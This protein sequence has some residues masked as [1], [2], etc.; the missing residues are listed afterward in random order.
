MSSE[1][2][3]L[4]SAAA[5]AANRHSDQRRKDKGKTPYINH[6][7]A[8]A[9]LL[10]VDGNVNDVELLM[11]ALL[12]DTV[13]DTATSLDELAESFGEDVRDLV[14]EVSDDKSLPKHRRKEL[15]VEN[16][17]RKSDSAKQL[18]IADKICNIRDID[19]DSPVGWDAERKSQYLDWASK[20]VDG[21]RGVNKKLDR[22][23]DATITEARQRLEKQRST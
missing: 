2:S 9:C 6:P 20:V 7:L 18:K 5:F 21:C 23:F 1:I 3:Q 22:L 8:V 12:H 19:G 4:I 17:P 11:A 16:A 14:A 15:Q 13:E 10:A